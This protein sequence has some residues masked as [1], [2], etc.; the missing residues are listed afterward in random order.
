MLNRCWGIQPISFASGFSQLSK[1]S[2][3]LVRQ[4]A[5]GLAS[6]RGQETVPSGPLQVILHRLGSTADE[7][8]QPRNRRRRPH[9]SHGGVR[10]CEQC[11]VPLGDPFP[12]Q[13]ESGS[14]SHLVELRCHLVQRPLGF[15]GL[16]CQVQGRPYVT[17]AYGGR[18]GSSS[19]T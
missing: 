12:L 3:G 7:P 4:L 16:L 9:V 1:H 15:R 2:S 10:G 6:D 13:G 5:S 8:G 17:T 11:H 14:F 18:N 19:P